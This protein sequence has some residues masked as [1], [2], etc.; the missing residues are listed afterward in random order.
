MKSSKQNPCVACG[1]PSGRRK[2][3]FL[4]VDISE[5]IKHSVRVV[6]AIEIDSRESTDRWAV[7]LHDWR[8]PEDRAAFT[9][10]DAETLAG[11]IRN[12]ICDAIGVPRTEPQ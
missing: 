2:K 9:R 6:P 10:F 3:L 8:V 4:P 7:T 1:D 11:T 12:A 5:A